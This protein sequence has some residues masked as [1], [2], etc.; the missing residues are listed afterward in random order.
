VTGIGNC[1]TV[2]DT[3]INI[4]S[5]AP[6]NCWITL[7]NSFPA[8]VTP[9]MTYYLWANVHPAG[10]NYTIIWT[11]N[12]V[13]FDTT[14]TNSTSYI[15]SSVDDTIKA[16]LFVPCSGTFVSNIKILYTTS[17][18]SEIPSENNFFLTPNPAKDV[19]TIQTLQ[20]GSLEIS[21]LT[22]RT[23]L[24]FKIQ[25]PTSKIDINSL[26]VGVYVYR[27]VTNDGQTTQ[28]KL[29]IVR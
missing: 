1:T 28:G 18:V 16:Y 29:V 11:S 15:K 5:V 4:T 26:D 9:G 6:Q 10:G 7:D 23:A 12:G 13:P 22:G 25:S 17:S 21:D 2:S 24:Q 27:F 20:S 14:Y 8:Y 19:V 3:T